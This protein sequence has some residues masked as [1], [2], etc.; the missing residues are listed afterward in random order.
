MELV[1]RDPGSDECFLT[2]VDLDNC[3]TE[4]I[5]RNTFRNPLISSSDEDE[6]NV[7]DWNQVFNRKK[8]DRCQRSHIPGQRQLPPYPRV[9]SLT[10]QQHFQCLK[11]ISANNPFVEPS[12]YMPMPTKLDY[13]VFEDVK[14]EYEKEQKEFIDWAKTL[15]L[16]NHCIRALRPKAPVE[17]TYNARFKMKAH[18]L[19]CYPK[20]YQLAAQIPLLSYNNH[21]YSFTHCEDLVMVDYKELPQMCSNQIKTKIC[22]VR[23]INVPEPCNEH[24]CRFILP[25]EDTVTVL[26]KTE[27]ERELAQYAFD[28]GARC[29]A[30][31][32]ALKCLLELDQNWYITVAVCQVI[33]PD[34]DK[35]NVIVLGSEFSIKKENVLRRSYKAFRHLLEEHLVPVSEKAKILCRTSQKHNGNVTKE[36]PAPSDHEGDMSSDDEDNLCIDL[37]ETE[38][39][40]CNV[41]QEKIDTRLTKP[42]TLNESV[43]KKNA[44]LHNDTSLNT[45]GL[46]QY[47]CTCKDTTLERPSPRSFRRWR[48]SD[49]TNND[50]IHMIVHAPHK[51]RGDSGEVILEPIPEYQLELGGVAM[52]VERQRSLALSLL[53]RKNATAIKVRL[54][55]SS[56]EIVTM[57]PAADAGADLA[58]H[59][60]RPLH[61]TTE[62]LQGLVPGRYLLR[63]HISH[64]S[65][66]LLYAPAK[67][68]GSDS[69]DLQF[70]L[71]SLEQPDEAAC[72]KMAPPLSTALLPIHKLRKVL[73][74]AFTPFADQ[75][76]RLGGRG[77]TG[78]GA[79]NKTPPQAIKCEAGRGGKRRKNRQRRS[80]APQAEE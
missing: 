10:P 1:W 54:D 2:A 23:P 58:D 21:K 46:G 39:S 15:W 60:G 43:S 65:N 78:A 16:T 48:V 59:V 50:S 67:R 6:T 19:K 44:S 76:Q 33:G 57:E 51:L 53:L 71:D 5:L 3:V 36:I 41:S 22:V 11:V 52:S 73:P 9:S 42:A 17:T 38:E 27:V 80:V 34:G 26:P 12:D 30:S 55:A 75:L 69:L 24:P 25:M 72:L 40:D 79:R 32:S 37:G 77:A 47:T 70:E 28:H 20:R 49:V 8:K 68:A 35:S 14:L 7:V 29:I 31:E 74:C 18:E 62:Q 56:G 64:G 61:T 4:K 66:A 45:S 13:K 63:H